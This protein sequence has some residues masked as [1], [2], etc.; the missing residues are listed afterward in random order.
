MIVKSP[1]DFSYNINIIVGTVHLFVV[2]FMGTIYYKCRHQDITVLIMMHI[3]GYLFSILLLMAVGPI[4][5]NSTQ[6]DNDSA[7]NLMISQQFTLALYIMTIYTSK[8]ISFRVFSVMIS[9]MI[10]ALILQNYLYVRKGSIN[11]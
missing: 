10:I 11:L 7:K 5:L 2:L 8:G 3:G 4:Y 9:V 1:G 6:K